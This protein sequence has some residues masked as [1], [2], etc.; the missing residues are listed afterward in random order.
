M[1][2]DAA[3]PEDEHFSLDDMFDVPEDEGDYSL[4]ELSQAYAQILAEQNALEISLPEGTIPPADDVEGDASEIDEEAEESETSPESSA[5]T[6][7]Q[8]LNFKQANLDLADEDGLPVIP[9][10]VVESILFVGTPDNS[11]ISAR[12]IASLMRGVSPNEVDQYVEKLNR[13][14]EA[15]GAAYRIE[16]EDLG[17]RMQLDPA[18]IPV[19]NQ[20]YGQIKEAKLNQQVIDV[21]S[22]VAY[23]QPVERAEVE[24]LVG[25]PAGG[26]LN[27]LIRR[28]L[29]IMEKT[30]GKTKCYR[31]T[32]RF[33]ELFGLD[34][35][36]DLP[37]SEAM[38]DFS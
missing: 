4:D 37:Q 22:V 19:R 29:I 27:Q 31:T 8:P 24:R 35:I 28:N 34:E 26:S 20:F 5:N 16:R 14:Y 23:H 18:M 12:L 17:Y 9:E 15:E 21:L 6:F 10:R 32:Q 33:L 38:D 3:G 11:P 7:I 36:D 13:N 25:K 2:D 1:P 30:E